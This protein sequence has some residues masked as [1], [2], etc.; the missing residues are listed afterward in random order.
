MAVLYEDTRQQVHGGVDKHAAKHR[1]WAAHGVEV[2]RKALKTGDYAADGSNVLVDTKRNMDE[3][4]QNIGGRGHDR[5]KRE[6][7]R[8]QDAGCRLVVLVENAQGYHCLN[9]VNA[10]T[11]GHC[12]RCVHYKRRACQPM[13]LGRC[14]KH[15]TKKPIQ[16]PRLAKAMATMEER[17]GVR[18]MFCAPKES[19]RIVCELL[20][21]GYER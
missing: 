11:N 1:W 20:G 4:A 14:L 15:G 7:V 12:L 10:W 21:V 19:A 2:V 18:F 9:N 6:C 5:F 16:G 3:I 17:Y 13:R 8:A